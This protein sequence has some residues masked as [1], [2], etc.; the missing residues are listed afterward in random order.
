MPSGADGD[1]CG[2]VDSAGLGGAGELVSILRDQ[3]IGGSSNP[4]DRPVLDGSSHQ[5]ERQRHVFERTP[6][7][8]VAPVKRALLVD[9]IG[10][11]GHIFDRETQRIE[12][13]G[14]P[15]LDE[16]LGVESAFDPSC[17]GRAEAAVA[18]EDEGGLLRRHAQRRPVLGLRP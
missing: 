1:R 3:A 11:R 16:D 7:G 2:S 18:I 6:D 4:G 17:R 15:P 13:E 9:E 14:L 10:G 12:I 5:P 8:R